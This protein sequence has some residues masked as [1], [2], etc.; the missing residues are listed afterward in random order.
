MPGTDGRTPACNCFG[1]WTTLM[2]STT[3]E[4]ERTNTSSSSFS[5]PHSTA[6]AAAS[7][8]LKKAACLLPRSYVHGYAQ[9]ISPLLLVTVHFS[10]SARPKVSTPASVPLASKRV[11]INTSAP[12]PSS[13]LP[14]H[15]FRF[16]VH[17]R[18]VLLSSFLPCLPA[19]LMHLYCR[20]MSVFWGEGKGGGGG[21]A[22]SLGKVAPQTGGG[23]GGGMSVLIL[24]GA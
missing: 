4:E 23:G 21:C 5:S 3:K 16:M 9:S 22:V 10:S 7:V 13:L 8:A 18:R 17:N 11:P 1:D 2:A 12:S 24:M 6:E 15:K 19:S 14:P 20:P